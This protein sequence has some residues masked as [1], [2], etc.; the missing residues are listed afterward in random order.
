VTDTDT[1]AS[2]PISALFTPASDRR[3]LD[4]LAASGADLVILD[5][6]DAIAP[7]A[8]HEARRALAGFAD[9]LVERRV[10]RHR[11][12]VRVNAVG[13]PWAAADLAAVADIEHVGGVMVPKVEGAE[14]SRE[15]AHLRDVRPDLALCAGVETGLGVLRVEETAASG[16]YASAYFGAEDLITD[17]GGVRTPEGIEVLYARSR[18][19]LAMR[20]HGLACFDQVVP[21]YQDDDRF[22][23]DAAVGRS[24][25][26][27]GKLCIHPRQVRLALEAFLPTADEVAA[28][29]RLVAQLE[30]DE[31]TLS[32]DGH[33][34]DEPMLRRARDILR[35]A[36]PRSGGDP[37]DLETGS[38]E[39]PRR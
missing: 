34:I 5:L 18:V 24:L 16:H 14:L 31:P 32:L 9:A 1:P 21:A 22:L 23:A 12:N 13:T 2:D 29:R 35:R 39:G 8:K 6:E 3:R 20:V 28:A 30:G 26:Y 33:M 4:R 36:D 11:I 37:R 15:L 10:A 17:I 25:G 27:T 38:C 19:V 7:A